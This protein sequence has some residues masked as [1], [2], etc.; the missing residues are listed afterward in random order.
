MIDQDLKRRIHEKVEEGEFGAA[1]I[2][3]YLGL[4][5][6]IGS[7]TQDVQDEVAGWDRRI[8]FRFDGAEDAWITVGDGAFSHGSGS[9]DAP[10]LVLSIAAATAAQLFAGERDAKAAF[11]AGQLKIEGKIPDALKFQDILTIVNEEI[12]Y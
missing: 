7:E 5:A 10:D 11:M 3:E 4:L 2:P 9:V 1:D 6:Q 8:Q 12:E